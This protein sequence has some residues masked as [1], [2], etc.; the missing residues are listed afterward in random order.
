MDKSVRPRP[1]RRRGG[2]GNSLFAGYRLRG[3]EDH[4]VRLVE[5][6]VRVAR[7]VRAVEV[8]AERTVPLVAEGCVVAQRTAVRVDVEHVA[9]VVAVV[10]RPGDE[11]VAEHHP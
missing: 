4:R 6:G 1:G 8:D 2:T 5:P 11:V 7:P 3:H 9:A 10:A